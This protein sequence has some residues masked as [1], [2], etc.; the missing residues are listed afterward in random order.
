MALRGQITRQKS[1]PSVAYEDKDMTLNLH[2]NQIMKV[3]IS[4]FLVLSFFTIVNIVHAATFSDNGNGTVTELK[5]QLMWQR[6]SAPSSE[7]S[8]VITPLSYS[9]DNALAYCNGLQLGG[10]TDW[11][12]PNIKALQSIIDVTKTTAPSINTTYF[13]DTL[14]LEYWSSTTF[15]GTTIHAW[16][17]NFDISGGASVMTSGV[18]KTMGQYVR[19]VRGG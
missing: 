18:D 1:T 3:I 8:C 17:I 14:A 4:V 12:L 5:S 10:Y 6:C 13:P 11:R 7:I 2:T 16:Y 15:M 9:W 19:C